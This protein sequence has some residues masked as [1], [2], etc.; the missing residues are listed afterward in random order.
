MTRLVSAVD[1]FGFYLL[2][3]CVACAPIAFGSSSALAA[4]SFGLLLSICLLASTLVPMRNRRVRRLYGAM[5][6]LGVIVVVWCVIQVTPNALPSWANPI[7][8][9]ARPLVDVGGGT[10]SASRYQPLHSVGYVL[11][12]L[13][14]FLCALVYVRDGERCIT[15][16]H[17]LLGVSVVVTLGSLTQYMVSPR[18]LVWAEKRHYLDSFTGTFVNPNNA[19]TYFGV[20]L[21][22][23]VS[24]ALRQLEKTGGLLFLPTRGHWHADQQRRQLVLAIYAAI[25][26]VFASA[27]LL[28]K[29]RAGIISSAIGVAG[30]T[31]AYLI[32]MLRRW[33]TMS[34]AVLVT[35]LCLTAAAVWFAIDS[36][37][38]QRRLLLEGFVDQGRLCVYKA[39]WQ[40]IK[41]AFW[42]GSGF[43]TFQDIY[44][45]YRSPDCGLYGY[46]EMAHNVF[47]EGWL[48]LGAVFLLCTGGLYALLLKT[49]AQGWR[50]R[51][52]FRFVPLSC[53]GVLV[54]VTLHSLVDFS[55]QIPG[56]ALVVAAVLGSGAA[57]SLERGASS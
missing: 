31:A 4:G 12:P 41:D 56:V 45:S 50:E 46:W 7:W 34:K 52:A 5:L 29:S 53:L 39:T 6:L 57:V 55:V 24:L 2:V 25:A 48:G 51:Q 23:A 10:I 18:M 43:G 13:A 44:P 16:L 36:G 15:F 1:A 33:T 27:L 28:T 38:L 8:D 32:S 30:L 21:L 11:L 47:L 40:A 35:A 17:L 3:L 42:T 14:A 26:L 9:R 20:L 49:Y 54:T 37:Y 19:A 22:L